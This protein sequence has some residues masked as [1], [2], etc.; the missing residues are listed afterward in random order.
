MTTPA[1]VRKDFLRLLNSSIWLQKYGVQDPLEP[2]PPIV[3]NVEYPP[4]VIVE[5]PT[6]GSDVVAV[7]TANL[8]ERFFTVS[9]ALSYKLVYI[10]Y[11]E[12]YPTVH[13]LPKSQVDD[14]II[15]ANATVLQNFKQVNEDILSVNVLRNGTS[16]NIRPA[17][18]ITT[19]TESLPAWAIVVTL[20][21]FLTF[22]TSLD[23]YTP[24]SFNKLQPATW[25][26]LED[27][28][29]DFSEYELNEIKFILNQSRFPRVQPGNP[30]SYEPYTEITYPPED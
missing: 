27:P 26:L 1:K 11:R 12:E 17:D 13:S 7:Q 24:E 28:I 23:E 3:N 4:N 16:Y 2:D 15:K 20:S 29:P 9:L 8:L 21:Y 25:D 10:F 5:I 14:L 6:G 30:S 19:T 18:D 22:T